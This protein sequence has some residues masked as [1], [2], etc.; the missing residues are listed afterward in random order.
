LAERFSML[1]PEVDD[2]DFRVLALLVMLCH[3]TAMETIPSVATSVITYRS[4][5]TL[6][7]RWPSKYMEIGSV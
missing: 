3:V 7:G 4:T 6:Y 2:L 1:R 5:A